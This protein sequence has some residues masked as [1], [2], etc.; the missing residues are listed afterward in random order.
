MSGNLGDKKSALFGSASAGKKSNP[1]AKKSTTSTSSS[2]TSNSNNKNNN[3]SVIDE[4]PVSK[5]AGMEIKSMTS[6]LSAE[7]KT[8]KIEEAKDL[9]TRAEKFLK[10]SVFQWSPDHIGAAPLFERS[11]EAYKSAGDLE[12]SYSM[13]QKAINSH[14]DSG[15]LSAAAL[16]CTKASVVAEGLQVR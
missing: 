12:T 15:V 16:A 2:N 14:S 3:S 8:K 7:M 5:T 4:K 10:T 13:Y 1:K 6:S 11:A 9:Q